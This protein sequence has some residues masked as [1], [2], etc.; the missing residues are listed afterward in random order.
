MSFR[1]R[2]TTN[3]TRSCLPPKLSPTA[4]ASSV[5]DALKRGLED[6]YP[7]EVAKDFLARFLDD[8]KALERE[9][10]R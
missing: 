7:G 8:P 10:A 1:D 9:L 2:S 4:L 5:V 3:G 6:V